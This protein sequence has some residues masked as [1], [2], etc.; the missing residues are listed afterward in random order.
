[1]LEHNKKLCEQKKNED[2]TKQVAYG[3]TNIALIRGTKKV[4]VGK[5][6]TSYATGNNKFV[7]D[8]ASFR[9][10]RDKIA[11]VSTFSKS[12]KNFELKF[13]SFKDVVG[14]LPGSSIRAKVTQSTAIKHTLDL[15][16]AQ[17][18]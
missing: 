17:K 2:G 7:M 9:G 16:K 15:M 1:M 3:I 4:A 13:K 11:S 14:K 18:K 10:I 12:I 6:N 5:C 8:W